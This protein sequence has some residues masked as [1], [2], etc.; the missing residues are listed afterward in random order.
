MN[1]G[2]WF[3]PEEHDMYNYPC[4]SMEVA[5]N[6]A[7][8]YHALTPAKGLP[9]PC[10]VEHYQANAIRDEELIMEQKTEIERLKMKHNQQQQKINSLKQQLGHIT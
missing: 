7:I 1:F 6:A 2:D 4:E 8:K 5:W 9:M 3:D 10:T